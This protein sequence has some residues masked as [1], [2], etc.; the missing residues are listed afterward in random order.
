MRK[1]LTAVLAI[2]TVGLFSCQKEV[3]DV[4]N[5]NGAGNGGGSTSGLLIKT[6]AMTGSDSLVTLYTYDNQ[7]RLE[8]ST[9]D[10]IS[11]G[12]KTHSY[13]K[14]IRDASSRISK[15]L[16]VVDQNGTASDTSVEIVHYPN[17]AMEFNY[18]V[19]TMNMMGLSVIDSSVYTYSSGK[20]TSMTSYLS[21]VLLGSTPLMTTKTDFNYDAS[22]N[23]SAIKMYSDFSTGTM[24]PI[25][26][27]T[28]TYGSTAVNA[29]WISNNGA[30]NFL[31]W[32]T[33]G[34]SNKAFSKAQFDDLTT[35][36]NS[37]S[38]NATYGVGSGNRPKTATM[39]YSTG[40]VTNYTFYYQ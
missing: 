11:G 14:F 32:G 13:K 19:N 5:N 24:D 21:S 33:P 27:Q 36:A 26:N 7:N 30:Q 35:P 18:T 17:S 2:L 20:M 39:V 1:S 23:I 22:A 4:F 29:E 38:I 6:V 3:D 37:F 16:Q 15:V 12:L 40:A 8:T 25:M 31:L 28:F 34:T 10:G 9:M